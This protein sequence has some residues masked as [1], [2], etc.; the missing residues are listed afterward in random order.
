VVAGVAAFYASARSFQIGDGVAV[1][2][3]TAAAANLLGI[4]GGVVVFGES[5]G[6]DALTVGGRVAAFVL[7]VLSVSLL[8]APIRAQRAVSRVGPVPREAETPA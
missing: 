7:V 2:T 4:L 1:I 8:P 3:A 5:L 6:S